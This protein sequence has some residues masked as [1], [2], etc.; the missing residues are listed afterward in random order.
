MR[1]KRLAVIGNHSFRIDI[2]FAKISKESQKM[3]NLPLRLDTNC[4]K[5]ISFN[6]YESN[7]D[8]N[9]IRESTNL[10]KLLSDIIYAYINTVIIAPKQKWYQEHLD[11]V[12]YTKMIASEDDNRKCEE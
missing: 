10:P 9:T 6:L 3:Q 12:K 2:L 7:I 8:V 1:K 11:Y 4:I 5:L